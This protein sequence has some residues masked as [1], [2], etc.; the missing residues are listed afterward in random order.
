MV[1]SRNK[2]GFALAA[3]KPTLSMSNQ[4]QWRW[5]KVFDW[6]FSLSVR[7]K[8]KGVKKEKQMQLTESRKQEK[9]LT[10]NSLQFETSNHHS[11][12][13]LVSNFHNN[14]MSPLLFFDIIECLML[15]YRLLLSKK[16]QW[17]HC[18]IINY[19][20]LFCS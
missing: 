3:I 5:Q 16:L 17:V 1:I 2:A 7:N 18:C 9:I 15:Y 6:L 12:S 4:Y 14:T 20:S 13:C 19:F 10:E 8:Q 11:I